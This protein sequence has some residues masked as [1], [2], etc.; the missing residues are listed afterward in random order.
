MRERGK[1]KVCQRT[2]GYLE[3]KVKVLRRMRGVAPLTE[4]S[5]RRL[6]ARE[7]TGRLTQLSTPQL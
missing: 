2:D 3:K 1:K 6:G 7:L 5:N 4:L